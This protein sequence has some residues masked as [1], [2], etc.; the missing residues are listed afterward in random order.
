MGT[1]NPCNFCEGTFLNLHDALLQCLYRYGHV[2]SLCHFS[3][4]TTPFF[5]EGF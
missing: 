1:Y 3:H 5:V 4:L 2:D